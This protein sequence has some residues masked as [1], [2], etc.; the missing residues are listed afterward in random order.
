MSGPTEHSQ[1]DNIGR[2][3]R[4]HAGLPERKSNKPLTNKET[5]ELTRAVE[6]E[7]GYGGRG[8]SDDLETQPTDK[9]KDTPEAADA[10]VKVKEHPATAAPKEEDVAAAKKAP[11]KKSTA[12]KTTAKKGGK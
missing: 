3:F 8:E 1:P 5:S 6:P 2:Q 9:A 11:A 7:G 10:S 12:K 4:Q